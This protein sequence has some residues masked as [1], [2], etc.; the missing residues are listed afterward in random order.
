MSKYLFIGGNGRLG[1]E[2][3]KSLEND[4]P[5]HQQ[6]D[7]LNVDTVHAWLSKEYDAI[8]HLAALSSVEACEKNKELS[9]RTNVIGTRN[10]AQACAK[11][12]KKLYF[13]ST[14]Y[15][16][17]GKQGNYSENDLP[18]PA[19]WYGFTKLAGEYEILENLGKHSCCI[20]RT[21]FRPSLWPFET[22]Y[23]NVETSADYTDVIGREIAVAI[24]YDTSGII[25]I[26]T[27]KKT[28]FELAIQRNSSVLPEISNNPALPKKRTLN[29]SKWKKIKHTYE[30]TAF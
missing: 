10:V 9:Y 28:L 19:N 5:T 14:D 18:S 13:I 15:V 8:I 2:L 3:Q 17:D 26:G 4:S 11:F 29:L 24:K 23:T 25:H 20:I 30:T 12:K 16:F 1:T 27:A 22:A 6:L 7:I 21:S